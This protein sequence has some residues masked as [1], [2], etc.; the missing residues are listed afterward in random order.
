MAYTYGPKIVTNGLVLCLDA[1]DRNSYPGTG[2]SWYD[3]SGNSNN[4]TFL[5]GPLFNSSNLGIINFDGTNDHI[6]VSSPND[7][8]SWTPSGVG[9]NSMTIE[10]WVKSS[11]VNGYFISKPWNGAGEYNYTL[12]HNA[13]NYRVGTA[14]A[15]GSKGVSFASLA[16]N[17][18][19]H[20]ACV[21]NSTQI[22]VYRNGIVNVNLTNH[23][24]VQNSPVGSN[25]NISLCIMNLYPYGEGWGGSSS[26]AVSG[27]LSNIKIYNR[28]LS[29]NEI[30]QNYNALK[31]RFMPSMPPG[32]ISN[33]FNSPAQA[34][35]LGYGDGNYYFLSGSMSAPILLEFKN[36]YYE[37][38][39]WVCVFRSPYNSTATTNELGLNIPMGGLLVQRDTLDLRAAVY[40]SSP[41]TYNAVGGIGNNT[42]DSGYSPRRVLLGSAGGHGI[43]ATNQSQCNWSNGVGAIGAGWNGTTCGSFPNGLLWGTGQSNTAIYANM[44]GVWSHWVYWQ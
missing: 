31:G 25:S 8:F 34:Q 28:L 33:P 42:A 18:W 6:A 35:S 29:A 39:S 36:N 30:L 27:M 4:V 3:L 1:G 26:F 41:I 5:N 13:L 23:D 40:W 37:N 43:Y 11:D 44:S 32:T 9:M 38:K 14:G 10:L 2:A 17:N 19:E 16:T 12:I 21:I 15:G 7:R 24:I 20:I 22:G